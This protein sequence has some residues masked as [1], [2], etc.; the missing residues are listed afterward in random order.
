MRTPYQPDTGLAAYQ[1]VLSLPLPVAQVAWLLVALH[2]AAGEPEPPPQL[3]A[4]LAQEGPVLSWR[5][6]ET[7]AALDAQRLAHLRRVFGAPD[8]HQHLARQLATLAHRS[9]SPHDALPATR[10]APAPAQWPRLP[11]P[12]PHHPL[13]VAVP[14]PPRVAQA[15]KVEMAVVSGAPVSLPGFPFSDQ[16][17]HFREAI[18]RPAPATA[19]VI[20]GGYVGAE[21]ALGWATAGAA[22]TL[23]E[24]GDRL[25]PQYDASERAAVR[26]LLRD[27]GVQARLKTRAT[28]WARR[29]EAIVVTCESHGIV[30]AL[31]AERVLVA[32]GVHAPSPPSRTP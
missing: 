1:V 25:L 14:F 13:G 32:V 3:A 26:A 2:H 30:T 21:V 17:I 11:P 16:I 4:S 31:S 27:G 5:A 28:A 29:G 8:F 6:L 20:G 19:V 24:R 18:T 9:P 10:P 15:L 12:P 23:I 7:I 22:V